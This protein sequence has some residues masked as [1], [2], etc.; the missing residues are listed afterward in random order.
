MSLN[1]LDTNYMPAEKVVKF[2]PLSVAVCPCLTASVAVQSFWVSRD[3]KCLL[4]VLLSA[5]P[6]FYT[7]SSQLYV[8][9]EGCV[10]LCRLA[11]SGHPLS[12]WGPLSIWSWGLCSGKD[13]HVA[14]FFFSPPLSLLFS[15]SPP[16]CFLFFF[17]SFLTFLIYFFSCMLKFYFSQSLIFSLMCESWLEM[18][19]VVCA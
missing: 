4:L 18:C 19:C 16:P 14:S 13:S 9:A 12:A 2:F 10:L 15:L 1:V 17:L 7:E 5:L 8:H 3:L 11:I 6:E